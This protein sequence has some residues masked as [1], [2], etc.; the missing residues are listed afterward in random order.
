MIYIKN[1]KNGNNKRSCRR[2]TWYLSHQTDISEHFLEK[3]EIC[4]KSDL[5]VITK[6][7]SRIWLWFEH[8]ASYFPKRVT[9]SLSMY[10]KDNVPVLH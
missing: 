8:I 7:W 10:E 1:I 2:E 3:P 9:A 6:L 4:T 5:L